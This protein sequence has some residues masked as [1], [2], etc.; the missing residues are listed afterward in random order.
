MAVVTGAPGLPLWSDHVAFVRRHRAWL[1]LC[2]ALGL[3]AGFVWSLGQPTLYS[4]TASVA[5][6]PVPQYVTPSTTE[7]VAPAVSVDTDAQLLQSPQV[8]GAVA[9]VL[10][11]SPTTAV[12]RLSVTASPNSHVLHVT[13]TAGSPA[14]AAA[15]ADAA[16]TALLDVRRQT[17]GGLQ[18]GQLRMLAS[19][20]EALL[21]HEQG[22]GVVIASES[23]LFA[24]V[25]ELR[26]DLADLEEARQAPG[27]VISRAVPPLHANPADTEV[28]LVSGAMAG[29]LGACLLGAALD[30]AGRLSTRAARRRP[31]PDRS[32]DQ[33]GLPLPRKDYDHAHSPAL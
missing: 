12:G 3:V 21:A 22:T 29:L 15:A 32:G 30:R 27:E 19:D 1:L 18:L 33:P 14:R 16:V 9:A 26:S 20:Q 11:S 17:L 31:V 25:Q 28:P 13:V 4:A 23:S 8:V 24:R 10:G 2:A 5:L 6:A 7:T